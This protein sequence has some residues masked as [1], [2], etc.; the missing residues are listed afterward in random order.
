MQKPI[1][2]VIC[3]I[4]QNRAIGKNNQLL[5][6][7]P[8]DFKH[9]KETTSGHP[10]IMGQRTYESIGR[11]LPNRTNIIITDDQSYQ[12]EGCV[13]AHSIDEAIEKASVVDQ[14]EIFFIGGG[15]IYRQA[16]PIADKLYLT[17]VEGE[18]EADTFFP[19]YAEFTKTVSERESCDE[20]YKYKFVELVRE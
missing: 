20:K 5:W 13:I 11:P 7:I 18:F 2:S 8:E 1:I 10:I 15:M 17:I 14:E 3:A 12:V 6:H 9:F 16:V 19:E 4:T